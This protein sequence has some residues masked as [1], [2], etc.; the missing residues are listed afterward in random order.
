MR[1]IVTDLDDTLL[2][3]DKT[4][5]PY[6]LDVLKRCQEKGLLIAFD[7]ARSENNARTFIAQA[8]PDIVIS[9]GGALTRFHGRVLRQIG[10]SAE[11]T[12]ALIAAGRTLEGPGCRITVDSEDGHHEN[13]LKPDEFYEDWGETIHTDFAHFAMPSMKICLELSTPERAEQAAKA[14]PSCHC[15]RFSGGNWYCF[16]LPNV[17]KHEALIDL[18]GRLDIPME[19]MI[20]FGDDYGDVGMIR[21]CGVGVAMGNAIPEVKAVANIVI[22]DCDQDAVARE[23]ENRFLI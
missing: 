22:G 12:A 23:L 3:R 4:L 17:S 11:E 19:D 18:S 9:C 20:A 10:F 14:V 7:T 2:R 1:L 5:S 21:A 13:F 8:N 6:T 15:L 16:T